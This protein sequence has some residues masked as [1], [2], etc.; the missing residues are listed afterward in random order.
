LLALCVAAVLCEIIIAVLPTVLC[1]G[2]AY[3]IARARTGK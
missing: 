2:I 3:L 1:C